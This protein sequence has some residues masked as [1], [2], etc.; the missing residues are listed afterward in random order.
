MLGV[1]DEMTIQDYALTTVGLQPVL[2]LFVQRF[3]QEQVYR[4]NWKGALS[5][6][7]AR[8]VSSLPASLIPLAPFLSS[9]P[10]SPLSPPTI[11]RPAIARSPASPLLLIP[12]HY[13]LH[14]LTAARRPTSPQSMRAILDWLRAEFG[15]AEAYVRAHT[16]L[17]A[18]DVEVVRRNMLQAASGV[19]DAS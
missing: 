6:A 2:P 10:L 4:D 8:C 19:G 5:I 15:S 16:G 1:D 18:E 13:P 14:A 11:P 9:R 7:T 17:S 12:T 3:S